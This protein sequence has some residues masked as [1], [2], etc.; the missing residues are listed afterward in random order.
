MRISGLYEH[1]KCL[2]V[3]HLFHTC[4]SCTL[5]SLHLALVLQC[6]ALDV[7]LRYLRRNILH[8]RVAD[9]GRFPHV[10]LNHLRSSLEQSVR[11]RYRVQYAACTGFFDNRLCI[12]R[13]ESVVTH[14]VQ[15]GF[16]HLHSVSRIGF[17]TGYGNLLSVAGHFQLVVV[18][19]IKSVDGSAEIC[20]SNIY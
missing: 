13:S 10:A 2:R 8:F 19:G 5:H 15:H 20:I 3:E 16:F 9:V 6:L 7:F 12:Q 14:K 11:S 4:F 1:L 18:L 17:G